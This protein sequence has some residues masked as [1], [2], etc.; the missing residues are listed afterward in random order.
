MLIPPGLKSVIP[1]GISSFMPED[2]GEAVDR[3]PRQNRQFR[4]WT[5]SKFVAL[6]YQ[7]DII[8]GLLARAGTAEGTGMVMLPTGAGKTSTAVAA[9]L[10]DLRSVQ[11]TEAIVVWIA[12]QVELLSQAAGTFERIWAAGEGPDSIDVLYC[13]SVAKPPT[14]ERPA[15]LLATPL[16]ASKYIQSHGLADRVRYLVFDEAHH[17]GAERFGAAWRE[18]SCGSPSRRLALGLSATPIRSE[19]SRFGELESALDRRIFY[20]KRLLP[21]PAATLTARG[22][23]AELDFQLVSGVPSHSARIE[24]SDDATKVLTAEPEY[25]MAC[26][27][28]AA[29]CR[30]GLFVYCPDR[31]SARLFTAHL[32]AIGVSAEYVDGEDSYGVRIAAM[33]RFRD[34]RTSVLVNVQLLLEGIDAPSAAAALV[35]YPIQSEIRRSQI[36]GRVMRGRALGGTSRATI[37]CASRHMLLQMQG[38]VRN[39]DYGGYWSRGIAL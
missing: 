15:V 16:V 20:P 11:S 12:P 34:G 28:C 4:R 18:L 23:L 24:R 37:L 14:S 8:D 6:D 26:V 19:G 3:D 31:A 39:T 35:T 9:V 22:V 5:A 21:D 27:K 33:E 38:A 2:R 10:R 25:W 29:E 30:A 1:D 32:R 13:R 36:V 17:L 7:A